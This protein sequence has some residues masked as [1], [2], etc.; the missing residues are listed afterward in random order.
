MSDPQKGLDINAVN[1]YQVAVVQRQMSAQNYAAL[2]MLKRKNIKVVYDLDDHLWAIPQWNPALQIYRDVARRS[3][4]TKL[5]T[6]GMTPCLELSD[7]VTT[8]TEF[9][10][11]VV[12]GKIKKPIPVTVVENAIDLNLFGRARKKVEREK[13]KVGWAGT[14][15]HSAD[16]LEAMIALANVA[17]K[18]QNIQV[19]IMGQEV[20]RPLLKEKRIQGRLRFWPFVIIWEYPA[21]YSNLDWDIAVAPLI[22][23]DFNLAKSPVKMM[24][25]GALGIPCLASDIG[26][27]ADFCRKSEKLGY[28]LCRTR[29]DWTSKLQELVAN[30]Q[31]REELG[32]EMNQVVREHYSIEKRIKE[33]EAVLQS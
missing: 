28:L 30:K 23:H 19:E 17:A 3:G 22:Q 33:W 11:K 4:E 24:E 6:E 14:A 32:Q 18:D 5:L 10:K 31:L 8:S 29:W 12:Q 13:V 26:P 2:D 25:A 15:T 27:Y 20:P 1:G 16:V 9:L 7:H 21:F